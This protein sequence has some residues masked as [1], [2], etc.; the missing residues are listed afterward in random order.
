MLRL[1]VI[2]GHSIGCWRPADGGSS[3]GAPACVA[4][5]RPERGTGRAVTRPVQ[6]VR[7]A[8]DVDPDV[9]RLSTA[10]GALVLTATVAAG[11]PDG[12]GSPNDS[13]S[14]ESD[15]W[16]RRRALQLANP[17]L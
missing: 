17:M 10:A 12:G 13:F 6:G 11:R 4:C 1:H 7:S 15:R 14:K 9:G 16:Q 5:R 3:G 8:A 2:K